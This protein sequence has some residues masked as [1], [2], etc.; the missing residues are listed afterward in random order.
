VLA[1]RGMLVQAL[2]PNAQRFYL[3]YGFVPSPSN[4]M[5]LMATLADLAEAAG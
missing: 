5:L 1:V 4:P 2:N 3:A